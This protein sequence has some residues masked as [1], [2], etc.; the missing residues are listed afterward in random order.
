MFGLEDFFV[1]AL[2]AG[3]AVAML[4]GPLGCFV[5]WRRMAYFG[6][7][8]AH[9]AL[10]GVALG[11]V[12]GIGSNMG[13]AIICFLFAL[14]ITLLQHYRMFATDTLLGILSHAA[15]SLGLVVIG[16]MPL[17]RVDLNSYLF[18]DI[19]AVQASDLW[20]ILAVNVVVLSLLAWLW[21]SLLLITLQEDLARAE[22]VNALGMRLVFMLMMAM[23]IAVAIQLIGILLITS[24]LIIPAATSRLYARSPEGMAVLAS[25]LGIAAVIGGLGISF[26]YDSPTG[27]SIVVM[28]TLLFIFSLPLSWLMGRRA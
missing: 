7:A 14:L 24:L 26:E 3:I 1:R 27:P 5:V 23:V 28:A 25:L 2:F 21:R 13:I 22:G 9:S 19:L 6:D 4:T 10:L 17:L 20:L 18:G 12:L 16:F 11:L 8:L 15:L